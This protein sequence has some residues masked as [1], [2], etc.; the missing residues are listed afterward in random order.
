MSPRGIIV[1]YTIIKLQWGKNIYKNSKRSS[2]ETHS[3]DIT[4]SLVTSHVNK[5]RQS[6]ISSYSD[7]ERC[8]LMILIK[9]G[10]DWQISSSEPHFV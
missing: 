4:I 5:L 7:I 2:P 9:N 8:K 3:D 6:L 10:K 1:K